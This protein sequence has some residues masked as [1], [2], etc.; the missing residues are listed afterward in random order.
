MTQIRKM[1][2]TLILCLAVALPVAA[3]DGPDRTARKYFKKGVAAYEKADYESARKNLQSA[4]EKYPSYA[5]AYFKLG[6]VALKEKNAQQAVDYYSKAAAIDPG[7]I[8][9]QLALGRIYMAARRSDEALLCADAVLKHDPGNPDAMLIKGSALVAQ[10]RNAEA[11]NLLEPVFTTGARDPNLIQLLAGA[12]FK[13]GDTARGESILKA[14][15]DKHPKTVALHLQLATLYLRTGD[16]KKAQATMETVVAIDPGNVAHATTLARFYRE[17]EDDANA[18]RLLTR[19]LEHDPTDPARRIAV[20]NAYL[21]DKQTDRA[22]DILLQGITAGD[23]GAHLRLALSELYIKTGNGQGAVDLLKKGL[24]EAPDAT[25]TESDH[26]RNALAKIYLATRD[27]ATAKAYAEAVLSHDPTNLQALVT[28]GMALKA[29]GQPE[30]AI[31]DFK[32]VLQLKPGFIDGYVQLA[33]AYA[34]NRQLKAAKASLDAGLRLAPT[35]RSLLMAAYR[36]CLRDKDY[37]QAETHLRTLVEKYP[38]AIDAQA[39]LGDFY[40]ALN[41]ESSARR[42]Y[43]EIFLKS[44]RSTVGHIKLARLYRRQGKNDDAILQLRKGYNLTRQDPTMAVELTT[45][46]MAAERTDEA[47]A[48]CDARLKANPDD[49]LA[50]NLK[51]KVLTRMKKYKAAQQSLEKAC[52]IAPNW[53]QASNDLASLFIL[54]DKK[55]QAIKRFEMALTRNPQNPVAYLTL[56]RLYEEKSDYKNAIAIYEKGVE[57]VPGFWSA[58]NRLAFLLADQATSMEE[59]ER[60]QKFASTAYRMKPGQGS[61]IDTLGWIH[62][63]KGETEKAL[64]LYEQLISA[65]PQDPLVNY[66]MGVV[67]EKSG[68]TESTRQK[69]QVATQGETPFSGRDHA[70]AMLRE[71][72]A[73]S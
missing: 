16:L 50:H 37:K 59:L 44:P 47:L 57:Q 56:G 23:P 64:H 53:P 7:H 62:Y 5:D 8:D 46:L 17:T 26:L 69:L 25:G 45:T 10:K 68:D 4:V 73:K 30:A 38:D 61:I 49:A 65:A 11:I 40:L 14:G 72:E 43:S 36:V 18:D 13:S 33:D 27:N 6:Q 51:G 55:K 22:R 2:I 67:L 39:E 15:I 20:A 1:L 58:A 19:T 29:G 63:K 42:E 54:Q 34:L 21:A 52:A 32:R 9:A 48:V 31:P 70:E 28:R 41:D 3:A 35:N 60:A 66:H 71:L 12:Y 24:D